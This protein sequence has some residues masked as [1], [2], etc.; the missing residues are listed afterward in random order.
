M[1]FFR[2]VVLFVMA[3]M[4]QSCAVQETKL[5]EQEGVEARKTEE[6]VDV[7]LVPMAD[8]PESLSV[9]FAKLLSR[10]LNVRVK[11]APGIDD[12]KVSRFPGTNQ[13]VGEEILEKSQPVLKFLSQRSPAKYYLLLTK[14]DIN[15]SSG[16]TRF[17]FS[18]HN[19][20]LNTS[21]VSM[22]R[23]IDYVDDKPTVSKATLTRVYKMA[24][25]AIGE[26]HLGWERST[27]PLDIMYSPIT[28]L[29]DIDMI[30]TKHFQAGVKRFEDSSE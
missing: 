26:L 3:L 23:M 2:V 10:E 22:A 7:Y 14:A 29:S 6:Q 4:L 20:N 30:G 5:P 27:N 21:V 15:S 17:Y 11:S 13:L 18:L 19:K 28:S 1:L 8:F 12:L 16:R 25:R 24:A 9:V